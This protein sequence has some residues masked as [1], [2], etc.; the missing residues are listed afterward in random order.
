MFFVLAVLIQSGFVAIYSVI[1]IKSHKQL[2]KKEMKR[3]LREGWHNKD[4]V[5]FSE[6]ELQSA[7]WEHSKEFFLGNSKY[8]VVRIQVLNGQKVFWCINDNKELALYKRLDQQSTESKA[9]FDLFKKISLVNMTSAQEAMTHR[10]VVN[11]DF[12]KWHRQYKYAPTE[13]VFRPPALI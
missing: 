12:P 13:T 8:D 9:V 3:Q 7:Q 1:A 6:P 5:A 4:L 11:I 2:V 10:L